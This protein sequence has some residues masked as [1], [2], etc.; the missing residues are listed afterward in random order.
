MMPDLQAGALQRRAREL[1]EQSVQLTIHAIHLRVH[2]GL[3][4]A[5]AEALQQ[6]VT[7]YAEALRSLGEPAHRMIENVRLIADEALSTASRTAAPP[8][9]LHDRDAVIDQL[10]L[11]AVDVYAA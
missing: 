3:A 10:V 6:T 1:R 4:I 9:L 2:A 8:P 5:R 11:W 7:S